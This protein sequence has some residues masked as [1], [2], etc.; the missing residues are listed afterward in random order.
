MSRHE[1]S[2]IMPLVMHLLHPRGKVSGIFALA[3]VPFSSEK[4]R[5]RINS[6]RYAG[7]GKSYLVADVQVAGAPLPFSVRVDQLSNISV[8][9][10][11]ETSE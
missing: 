10:T 11:W 1:I 8:F 6:V 9:V 3:P 5:A 4:V 7:L 2:T